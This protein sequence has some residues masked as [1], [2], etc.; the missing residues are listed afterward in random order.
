MQFEIEMFHN[1]NGD[2]LPLLDFEPW[3]GEAAHSVWL[4]EGYMRY[5]HHNMPF[6]HMHSPFILD[7]DND[8]TNNQVYDHILRFNFHDQDTMLSG[9]Q[10]IWVQFKHKNKVMKIPFIFNYRPD[11]TTDCTR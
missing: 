7:D 8:D 6:A 4:S 9:I 3:L 2:Y 10:K 11:I 1:V 5:M